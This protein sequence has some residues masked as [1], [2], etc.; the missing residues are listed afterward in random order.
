MQK[1]LAKKSSTYSRSNKG[2][3]IP[4]YRSFDLGK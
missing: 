2:V 4:I 3:G 1:V